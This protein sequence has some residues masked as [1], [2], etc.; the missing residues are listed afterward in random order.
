MPQHLTAL[1]DRLRA[2][3]S[4][5]APV[6]PEDVL[7]A[8]ACGLI[9]AR[10]VDAVKGLP[11]A[12]IALFAGY[13]I[14]S[15]DSLGA[16]AHEPTALPFATRLDAGETLPAGTNAVMR[17][18]MIEEIA[19][20]YS[21]LGQVAPGE[22][23]RFAGHD[24]APGL[25]IISAGERIRPGHILLLEALGYQH[26]AVCRP[27]IAITGET[28]IAAW[29]TAMFARI[30]AMEAGAEQADLELAFSASLP[31]KLALQPGES[32]DLRIGLEGRVQITCLPRFD[33]AI[34][35]F[36]ALVLPVLARMS[37]A[38]PRFL[39]RAISSGLR[40]SI[41][42][43]EIALFQAEPD[44]RARPLLVGSIT[45]EALLAAT[46]V[47]IV[48]PDLEGYPAGTRLQ[49]MPLESPF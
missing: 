29:L 17:P 35:A 26:I 16:T 12:N 4:T 45:F 33:A 5:L 6:P 1:D 13:A 48:P 20:L 41:G 38:S 11:V 37:G 9:A 46:H 34:A 15:E 21:A 25:R 32:A 44:G 47:A 24:L 8:S 3:L 23:V 7:L 22:G 2:V 28:E 42:L 18:D 31:P 36:I 27:R 10:D 40:S 19:G 30:G 49:M 14:A 43:S 39:E